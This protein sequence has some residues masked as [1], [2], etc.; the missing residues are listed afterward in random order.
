MM[1]E[2]DEADFLKVAIFHDERPRAAA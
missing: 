1:L 2:R